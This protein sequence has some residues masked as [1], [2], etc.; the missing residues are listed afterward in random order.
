MSPLA[1]QIRTRWIPLVNGDAEKGNKYVSGQWVWCVCVKM[2][3]CW[4]LHFLFVVK[5][6]SLIIFKCKINMTYFNQSFL[7]FVLSL[8]MRKMSFVF[9]LIMAVWVA[10]FICYV[11]VPIILVG[12]KSDLR[13]GSSMETILPIMNQFSEIETCVEVQLFVIFP[14]HLFTA[15]SSLHTTYLTWVLHEYLDTLTSKVI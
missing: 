2:T 10:L 1:F 9:F 6:A 14:P 3:S 5:L 15:H 8:M 11:R 4:T 12:N 13:C 7:I